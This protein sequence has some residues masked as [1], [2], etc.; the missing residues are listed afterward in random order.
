MACCASTSSAFPGFSMPPVPVASTSRPAANTARNVLPVMAGGQAGGWPLPG[1]S[2][3][4]P[5]AVSGMILRRS[6]S[7]TCQRGSLGA[8]VTGNRAAGPCLS[9]KLKTFRKRDISPADDTFD[10]SPAAQRPD[11]ANPPGCMIPRRRCR[12]RAWD[13]CTRKKLPSTRPPGLMQSAP[14]LGWD[15]R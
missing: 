10:P 13:S 7:L 11:H 6:S 12:K 8:M 14:Q 5:A 1:S 2:G 15:F 4:G 9:K 3:A